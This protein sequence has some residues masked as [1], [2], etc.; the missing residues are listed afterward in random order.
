[1]YTKDDMLVK[2]DQNYEKVHA[3][4]FLGY[5]PNKLKFQ[6]TGNSRKRIWKECLVSG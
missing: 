5:H 4:V 6:A 1:M 2:Q 3:I